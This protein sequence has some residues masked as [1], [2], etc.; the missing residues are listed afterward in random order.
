MKKLLAETAGTFVIVF[1]GTGTIVFS[2]D[3]DGIIQNLGI[4]FVFGVSVTVAILAFAR[5]SG[6]HF[7]PAVTIGLVTAG[8]FPL[9][10]SLGYMVSQLAG[11]I[12]ASIFLR[13]LSPTNELLGS[14]IPHGS[15]LESFTWEFTMTFILMAAVLLMVYTKTKLILLPALIIGTV[16]FLEAYLGGPISGASMNPARSVGPAL[17]SGNLNHLWIYLSAPTLGA[18][19]CA[20]FTRLS[21]SNKVKQFNQKKSN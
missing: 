17:V 19:I 6:G 9:R 2:E 4:S 1:F 3:F 18:I 7:N 13:V 15:N 5:I 16:I 21:G 8:K 14:T 20:V 10:K 12:L 11:A